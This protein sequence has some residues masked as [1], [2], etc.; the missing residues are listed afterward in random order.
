MVYKL[1][2]A[3]LHNLKEHIESREGP[4]QLSYMKEIKVGKDQHELIRL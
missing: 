4:G 3:E 2:E 1:P